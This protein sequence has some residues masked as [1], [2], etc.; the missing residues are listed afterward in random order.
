MVWQAAAIMGGLNYLGQR[1]ANRTNARIA[2]SASQMSQTNAREQMAF[3]DKQ[4]QRQMAFQER[5]S[6][7]AHQRAMA[8]MRAAGINPILAARQ[9]ASTPTGAAGSGAM[10]QVFTYNHQ[11]IARAAIDGYQIASQAQSQQASAKASIAQARA[12]TASIDK[13]AQDMEL[14]KQ[15]EKKLVEET[16]KVVQDTKIQKV[17]NEERWER[18][19]ATMGKD[20]IMTAIM[21]AR[22]NIPVEKVLKGFPKGMMPKDRKN[23]EDA[24]NKLLSG[25]SFITREFSGAIDLTKEAGKAASRS[26]QSTL[27]YIKKKLGF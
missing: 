1:S 15:Q 13:M 21:A 7:T 25:D 10:G 23:M 26:V 6:N 12:S 2:S 24:Y 22:F 8:D 5:M 17:L 14:S 16:K 9:P 11:N 3:Q 4:V 18:L 27:S 20:N 19:F